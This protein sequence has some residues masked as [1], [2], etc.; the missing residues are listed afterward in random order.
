MII[1]ISGMI[2]AGKSTL[3]KNLA[4]EFPDSLM[5]EEFEEDNEVFNTFLK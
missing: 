3:S 5:L 2:G 1:G 4:A